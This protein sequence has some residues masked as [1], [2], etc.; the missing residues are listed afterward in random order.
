[1]RSPVDLLPGYVRCLRAFCLT[2]AVSG[3]TR[4]RRY[5]VFV[6]WHRVPKVSRIIAL[7]HSNLSKRNVRLQDTDKGLGTSDG[8]LRESPVI[9]AGI[10][11]RRSSTNSSQR[12]CHLLSTWAQ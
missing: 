12:P 7:A 8:E 4:V 6:V 1:M 2:P 10:T 5:C 11:F 9:L 3:A